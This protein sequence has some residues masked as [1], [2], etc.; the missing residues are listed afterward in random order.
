MQ[1]LVVISLCLALHVADSSGCPEYGIEYEGSGKVYVYPPETW[2][3]WPYYGGA[4]RM[5]ENLWSILPYGKIRNPA[6]KVTWQ[7][8]AQ[9]CQTSREY[10]GSDGWPG[11]NDGPCQFWTHYQDNIYKEIGKCVFYT[12]TAQPTT[13]ELSTATSGARFC[14]G[15]HA[16]PLDA[17]YTMYGLI[18]TPHET[19]CNKYYCCTG[20]GCQ[21]MQPGSS[22]YDRPALVECRPG[23][24]YT[25]DG[26]CYLNPHPRDVLLDSC[27]N[28]SN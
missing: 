10:A 4:E 17:G 27:S 21:N 12:G 16:C 11:F 2:G 5:K 8:C 28:L 20:P 26:R 6:P 22:N 1:L 25:K 9:K 15:E 13:K 7:D 18:T 14:P 19:D 23:E 24:V 3:Q